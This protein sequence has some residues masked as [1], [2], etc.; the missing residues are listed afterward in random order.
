MR[1]PARQCT[2]CHWNPISR[3]H[4]G[5]VCTGDGTYVP[6]APRTGT[7]LSR[8]WGVHVLLSLSWYEATHSRAYT[9]IR[10]N[11][12]LAQKRCGWRQPPHSRQHR[13]DLNRN[14]SVAAIGA[15]V[16]SAV[17][18]L[19]Y[20]FHTVHLVT[21]NAGGPPIYWLAGPSHL[22]CVR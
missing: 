1:G 7:I 5:D 19:W 21:L 9:A 17:A 16:M 12:R 20:A 3:S 11:R 13:L 2:A 15:P 14:I 8:W 18:G 6:L 4:L 10:K 22:S